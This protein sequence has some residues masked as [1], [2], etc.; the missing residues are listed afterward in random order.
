[1]LPFLLLWLTK[2]VT[3]TL[4]FISIFHFGQRKQKF[5]MEDI[6]N[7][8]SNQMYVSLKV[9]FNTAWN[10]QAQI[11]LKVLE[12]THQARLNTRF[13]KKGQVSNSIRATGK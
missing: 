5:F 9:V 3:A 2:N 1:M 4:P 13:S 11:Y 12:Q 10:G 8:F 7:A 6:S